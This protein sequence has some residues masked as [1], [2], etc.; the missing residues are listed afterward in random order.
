MLKQLIGFLGH[1]THFSNIKIGI[2]QVN[3]KHLLTA[4]DKTPYL[5]SYKLFCTVFNYLIFLPILGILYYIVLK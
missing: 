3:K 4:I 2:K 5:L 1:N